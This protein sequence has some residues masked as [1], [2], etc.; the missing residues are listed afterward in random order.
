MQIDEEEN[1]L[2]M[3]RQMNKDPRYWLFTAVDLLTLA[4]DKL[5][6]KGD[7]DTR[8]NVT[9]ALEAAKTAL[10]LVENQDGKDNKSRDS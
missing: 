8:E 10:K 1:I 7:I 3:E 5:W 2:E 9:R 6:N 4:Q